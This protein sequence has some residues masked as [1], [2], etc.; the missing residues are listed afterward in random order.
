MIK[1][2]PILFSLL[3]SSIDVNV[4]GKGDDF[5]FIRDDSIFRP[6]GIPSYHIISVSGRTSFPDVNLSS[7]VVISPISSSIYT[8]SNKSSS[9]QSSSS[10]VDESGDYFSCDRYGPF[11]LTSPSDVDA[12]FTYRLNSISSQTIIERIR[13][14]QKGS[15]VTASTKP[16]FSYTK[17]QNKEITF[18]LSI[19]DYWTTSGLELRFEILNSSR[20]ILKSYSCDFYPGRNETVL[21]TTLKQSVYESR[22]V[23]FYGDGVSMCGLKEYFDFTCIGDYIDNDY[24]YRLDIGQNIFRYPNPFSLSYKN[25]KMR[26]NDSNYVFPYFTHQ[27]N[28]DI[29]VPLSLYKKGDNVS[30]YF[31]NKFYVNRK[32]LE[33]SDIYRSNYVLTSYFYLP[34]NGLKKFNGTTIYIDIEQLGVEKMTTTLPFKYD[35]SRSIVSSCSD[36]EYCVVGGNE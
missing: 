21:A 26:F 16:S 17:G 13:I 32:T 8:S 6:S 29:V 24:Y 15:V 7:L 4:K 28:G 30:F 27:A 35:M 19:R 14:L 18:T 34:I 3:V 1:I 12:T 25:I 10:R 20:Q 2:I 5:S 9:V 23:A 31:T 36:G 22:N 33:I 11:S